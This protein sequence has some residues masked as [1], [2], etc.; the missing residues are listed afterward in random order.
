MDWDQCWEW[1]EKVYNFYIDFNIVVDSW[2]V[3]QVLVD[4]YV[5]YIID[6]FF[7]LVW[8]QNSIIKDG[9]SVLV[10]NF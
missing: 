5:E 6:E 3:E 9:D 1:I 7:E 10:F 4:S 8:F 2:M